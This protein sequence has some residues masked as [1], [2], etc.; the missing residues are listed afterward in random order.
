MNYTKFKKSSAVAAE[1]ARNV[2]EDEFSRS[3]GSESLF[4]ELFLSNLGES[5]H[6]LYIVEN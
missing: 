1:M 5:H 6:K 2:A 4:S 3:S